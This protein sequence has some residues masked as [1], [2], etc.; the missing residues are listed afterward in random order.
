MV[1]VRLVKVRVTALKVFISYSHRDA[2]AA[3]ELVE[4]LSSRGFVV[5][6]D[7]RDL[8]FGEKWQSEPCRLH[9]TF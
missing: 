5:T 9:S 1:L 7:R 8:P 6:I 4:A 2:L 3:G